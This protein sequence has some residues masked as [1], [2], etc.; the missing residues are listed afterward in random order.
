MSEYFTDVVPWHQRWW[1]SQGKFLCD[2]HSSLIFSRKGIKIMESDDDDEVL[3]VPAPDGPAERREADGHA[4]RRE[5]RPRAAGKAKAASVTG[6]KRRPKRK[7]DPKDQL[8]R[9]PQLVQQIVDDVVDELHEKH[10]GVVEELRVATQDVFDLNA[11]HVT[12]QRVVATLMLENQDMKDI[13]QTALTRDCISC[14]ES[15]VIGLACSTDT[16]SLCLPC[17]LRDMRDP[18]SVSV[19][20]VRRQEVFTRCTGDTDCMLPVHGYALLC[21]SPA[22]LLD[23]ML[24]MDQA[25]EYERE[26]T[27]TAVM[28]AKLGQS[29][30][31]RLLLHIND[32]ILQL[33]C[34]VCK[35]TFNDFDACAELKCSLCACKFCGWCFKYIAAGTDGHDHVANCVHNPVPGELF[36]NKEAWEAGSVTYRKHQLEK[37]LSGLSLTVN[38]ATMAGVKNLVD[39]AFG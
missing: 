31:Q 37:F 27:N 13:H 10:E 29:D 24:A 25:K 16:H 7:T 11:L 19:L 30:T 15:D 14:M 18:N 23:L 35:K 8:K 2:T 9:L 34:P 32:Q 36:T 39:A 21:S 20:I 33:L 38:F 6:M 28:I 4:E 5:P 22:E 12:S 26:R 3:I 17:L 1:E